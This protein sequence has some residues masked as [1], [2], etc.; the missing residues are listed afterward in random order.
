MMATENTGRKKAG[1]PRQQRRSRASRKKLL[2]AARSVF[3]EKGLDST[4]IDDITERA[5]LGK[6]TFYNHFSGKEDLIQDLMES[7]I[8]ELVEDIRRGCDGIADPTEL[9]DAIIGAHIDFFRKRW[10]DYVLFFQGRADLHLENGYSGIDT[11]LIKYL[12]AIE[13]LIDSAI[14]GQ[15]S[16]STMRRI[17]CAVAGFVSG[18]YSFAVIATEGEDVDKALSSL[19]SALVAGLV[20]FIKEA[21]PSTSAEK[22]RVVW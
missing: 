19:R 4:R 6:G 1:I 16:K 7:V 22:D 3:A 11:P 18:Y 10:E 9:L 17:A 5:D 21:L 15:L 2:N 13:A 14:N 8:D 20:K 12:E